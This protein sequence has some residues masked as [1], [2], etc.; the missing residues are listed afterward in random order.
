MPQINIKIDQDTKQWAQQR[1]KANYQ[2]LSKFI[3]MLID[4]EKQR[5]KRQKREVKSEVN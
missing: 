1:A 3:I 2:S 4:K 5:S